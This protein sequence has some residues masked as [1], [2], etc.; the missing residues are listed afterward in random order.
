MGKEESLR[1]YQGMK[2]LA[3][4]KQVSRLRFWGKILTR[5]GDYLILEGSCKQPK[6]EEIAG[7]T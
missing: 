5:E 2:R 7:D 3:D 1:I 4:S 6:P